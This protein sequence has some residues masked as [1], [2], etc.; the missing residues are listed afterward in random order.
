[1]TERER[2]E[3]SKSVAHSRRSPSCWTPEPG[4]RTPDPGPRTPD[5]GFRNPE[6]G[7]LLRVGFPPSVAMEDGEGPSWSVLSMVRWW[8]SL[9]LT[10][11]GQR[12]CLER[13]FPPPHLVKACKLLLGLRA[14]ADRDG[15]EDPEGDPGADGRERA[16]ALDA[17]VALVGGEEAAVECHIVT[18]QLLEQF[19]WLWRHRTAAAGS[20]GG[21]AGER[22]R[23]NLIVDAETLVRVSGDVMNLRELLRGGGGGPDPF[24]RRRRRVA[25]DDPIDLECPHCKKSF[26]H[27]SD[28]SSHIRKYHET[29]AGFMCSFCGEVFG[30][31]GG[32]R[33]HERSSHGEEAEEAQGE[34]NSKIP[35]VLMHM[36]EEQEAK[37]AYKDNK[38][39]AQHVCM[40]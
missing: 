15:E 12:R 18:N 35:Q 6:S 11:R 36:E 26:L 5:P 39:L 14:E 31:R 24:R 8:D 30:S 27:R 20:G 2:E 40:V 17:R 1:M 3:E 13:A 23:R 9:G 38:A 32:L 19:H 28:L 21:A 25:E 33:E 16:A 7:L 10:R 29:G 22:L 4:P 37:G 34:L